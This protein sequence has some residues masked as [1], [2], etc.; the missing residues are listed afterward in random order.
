MAKYGATARTDPINSSDFDAPSS[1]LFTTPV[2][3][4][5]VQA[6]PAPAAA[7]P[8]APVLSA[9]TEQRISQ[10]LKAEQ[11]SSSDIDAEVAILLPNTGDP[12]E[13]CTPADPSAFDHATS[14]VDAARARLSESG[15]PSHLQSLLLSGL[16]EHLKKYDA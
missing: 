6:S 14:D 2:F 1:A 15:L 11:Q 5:N 12:A 8:A 13:V 4:S 10:A 7:A 16:E 9:E 3:S